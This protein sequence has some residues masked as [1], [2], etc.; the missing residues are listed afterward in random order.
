MVIVV[1]ADQRGSRTST[2]VVPETLARLNTHNRREGVLRRFERTVG[3]EIQGIIT[4]P[5][6]AVRLVTELA[7]S[8]SWTVGVGI[9]PV[10]EPLPRS[11]RAA[12]GSAFVL[13]RTAIDRA[14]RQ[15]HPVAV[16]AT[17][18]HDG[19]AAEAAWWLLLALFER[20]TEAGWEAVTLADQGLTYADIGAKLGVSPS[21]VGQRLR[22]AG[23]VEGRRGTELV[24]DLIAR[25]EIT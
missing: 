23:H 7:L 24:T 4:S 20:R 5:R 17:D 2:D 3:D 22:A 15:R 13:A 9:G 18:H 1:T 25:A 10:E 14:N 19:D 21:A 12:R 6:L 11:T 8:G 16:A